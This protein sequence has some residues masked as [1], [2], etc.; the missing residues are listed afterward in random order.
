V[1]TIRLD[2]FMELT[3]IEK[4]DFLKVDAQGADLAIIRSAGRRLGDVRRI[5]LEV[6]ISPVRLYEGSASRDDTITYLQD[7][8]F[9]L[10]DV[11]AQSYG[12]EQ[13]LT[14]I[15]QSAAVL[16]R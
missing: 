7:H 8:G 1:P 16:D 3:G 2:T 15:R 10:I 12:Q 4:V 9:V 13:N 6:D 5:T 14:F 11:Q